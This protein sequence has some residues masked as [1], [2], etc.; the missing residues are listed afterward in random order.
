MHTK[1][2]LAHELRSIGLIEMAARAEHGRYDDFLSSSAT[3][4]TDLVNELRNWGTAKSLAFAKRVIEGE[5]DATN[6]EAEAWAASP[7]GQET[8]AKVIGGK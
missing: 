8:I 5:F 2:R 1:D 3:P 6:E 7:D 4:L